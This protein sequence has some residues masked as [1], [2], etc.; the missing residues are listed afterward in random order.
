MSSSGG[1]S[2]DALLA[3]RLERLWRTAA[4]RVGAGED[5]AALLTVKAQD[6]V[7]T[8]DVLVDGVH[9]ELEHCGARAA[10]YKA[11]AVNLSD[12]AAMAARPLGFVV[13]AVLPRRAAAELLGQLLDEFA[14]ASQAFD[15]PLLGGDTNVADAPLSL[16]VTVLGQL[17][18]H[19]ALRR[20]GAQPGDQLSVTGPLGGSRSGRHLRPVPRID[21]AQ[22]LAASAAV[23][24]CLDLSDGLRRDLPRLCRASGVG[25]RLEA[26]HIPL[27]DDART[28]GGDPLEHALEDGEDFELLLA[29]APF[30]AAQLA[31]LAQAGVVL[32]G[33]GE[34]RPLSEGLCLV[35][36]GKVEPLGT[37][38][39]DHFGA[40]QGDT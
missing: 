10:A 34:V 24:A 1:E 11:L 25:A 32:H 36:R 35:R 37:G 39:W 33:I 22:A 40:R 29:H 30:S 16:A 3:P 2:E 7:V 17:G 9:F 21:E 18:P 38:G 23:H 12:L 14:R 27:H 13:G 26:E 5:D 31:A 4:V 8:T 19:G 28:V 20:C 6:L 15:C